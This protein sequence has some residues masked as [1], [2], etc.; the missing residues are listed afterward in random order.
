[1]R[2]DT[3]VLAGRTYWHGLEGIVVDGVDALYGPVSVAIRE[4]GLYLP[5]IQR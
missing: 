5:L 2:K 3:G 1:V 4:H